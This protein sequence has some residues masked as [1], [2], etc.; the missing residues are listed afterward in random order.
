MN[1][2]KPSKLLQ[3]ILKNTWVIHSIIWA[4][5]ADFWHHSRR[6]ESLRCVVIRQPVQQVSPGNSNS[7]PQACIKRVSGNR[8]VALSTGRLLQS[9]TLISGSLNSQACSVNI[10]K[11]PSE[12]DGGF[13]HS[14]ALV[15]GQSS[16][17]TTKILLT[18]TSG[19]SGF[20]SPWLWKRNVWDHFLFW[21]TSWVH[22]ECA[23]VK[24]VN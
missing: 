23:F 14:L 19:A 5:A 8:A 10:H 16:S 11:K 9:R 17:W 1:P 24:G 22:V 21:L 13:S 2:W 20:C 7:Q 6:D 12:H 4:D 18:L 15:N 3:L